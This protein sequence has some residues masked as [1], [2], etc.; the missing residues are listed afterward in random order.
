MLVEE[1]SKISKKALLAVQHQEA[2][3]KRREIKTQ[4]IIDVRRAEVAIAGGEVRSRHAA[5][6]GKNTL[7]VWHFNWDSVDGKILGCD[8]PDL[9]ANEISKATKMVIRHFQARGFEVCV[10]PSFIIGGDIHTF[11]ITIKW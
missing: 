9:H 1:L 8:N 11:A 4:E 6:D 5:E 3:Q 2:D 7:N 10:E